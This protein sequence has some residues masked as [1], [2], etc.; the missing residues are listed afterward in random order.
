[1]NYIH[2]IACISLGLGLVA[3]CDREDMTTP[4]EGEDPDPISCG[5]LAGIEC[6]GGLVCIDDP[7][8]DC[9]PKYGADCGGI[10]VEPEAS[11]CGGLGGLE[12][13]A[14][15]ACVDDPNDDC[16]PDN[17]G[18]DCG[19][20]CAPAPGSCGGF[21]GLE[22]AEGEVCVDDP[23]DDCDPDEGSADCIGVCEPAPLKFKPPKDPKPAKG[24][25]QC[26]DPD[27]SY[28]SRDP[29]TCMLVKFMCVAGTT[30]FSDECGC[31]CED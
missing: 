25:K 30:P 1:M 8:D 19:G 11:S 28:V 16:D 26:K 7:G 29:D 12:C 22:C 2:R 21:G 5:G 23:S 17:G 24:D 13:P 6:P 3:A 15:Q 20:V 31:G 18:A 4:R 10:C 14:G 9:H 27:R